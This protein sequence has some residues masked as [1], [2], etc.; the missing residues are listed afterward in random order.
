MHSN[1]R[2]Y[3]KVLQN[4]QVYRQFQEVGFDYILNPR[5]NELHRVGIAFFFGSHNL[6]FANL[7]NFIGITNIGILP[8][9]KFQEGTPIPLYEIITGDFI[10]NY[11]LRLCSY[12]YPR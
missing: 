1:L 8:I 12:C 5:T 10:G 2:L 7:E 9:D 11:N 4:I 3:G 6:T